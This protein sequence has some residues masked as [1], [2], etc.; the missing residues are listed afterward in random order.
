MTTEA[1]DGMAGAKTKIG[2][3]EVMMQRQEP[4]RASM[5]VRLLDSDV[6]G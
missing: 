5:S 4:F 6:R 3:I 2:G 1:E